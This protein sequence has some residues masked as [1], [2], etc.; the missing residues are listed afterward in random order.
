MTEQE[1]FSKMAEYQKVINSALKGY[2]E[3]REE[4][5]KALY[6]SQEYSVM[7]GG[8]R[9]RPILALAFCEL[10]GGDIEAAVPYAMALELIHTASLIHD[11]LPCIDNDDLRRGRPTNHVAFGEST[12][13]LAGDGLLIDAFSLIAGNKKLSA[14][15][16]I[17]AVNMLSIFS[18]TSGLVGGEFLDVLGETVPVSLDMLRKIHECKTTALIN[19]SAILGALSSGNFSDATFSAAYNYSNGIGIAFQIKDDMLDVIGTAEKL[20]KNPGSDAKLNK[21]TYLNFYSLEELD[22]LIASFT[23]SAKSAISSY[24]GKEFLDF[25][26]DYLIKR[27][28]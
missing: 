10:F 13:L 23:E 19:A 9:I 6:E 26:A 22:G 2:F 11:D 21:T 17:Q 8:K 12:A 20:G 18:G 14:E 25:L 24:Q 15:V 4:D 27:D 1:F 16:N 3:S 28:N 5:F 7:A